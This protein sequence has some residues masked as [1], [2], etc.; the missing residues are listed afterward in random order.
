[1][2]HPPHQDPGSNASFTFMRN[3]VLLNNADST[4]FYTTM[5]TGMANMTLA[6][7][8]YWSSAAAPSTLTFPPTQDPTS[9]AQWTAEG[10]DAGSIVADPQFVDASGF[11]FSHLQPTSPALARGFVPIDTSTVGPRVPEPSQ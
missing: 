7:N 5:P 4:L 6:D 8:V 3:I 1:M 2:Q 11:D 10:K 9:W